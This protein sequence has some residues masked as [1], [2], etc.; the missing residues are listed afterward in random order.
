MT[1]SL[2]FAAGLAVTFVGWYL[3]GLISQPVAR[4]VVRATLIAVLCSPGVVI[5]HG[6]AVVPALFALAV[7]PTIYTLG[8]M[9]IVWV[10]A[11]AAILGVPALRRQSSTWPPVS[12]ELFVSGYPGKLLLLGVL[13]AV[14]MRALIF[15]SY[16]QDAAIMLLK[17]ALFFAGAAVNLVLSYRVARDLQAPP[18][19]IALPFALPSL[20]VASST[21]P[22]VWYAA[23]AIGGLAGSGRHTAANRIVVALFLFL[24]AGSLFR[25]YLAANAEAHV[26]I[27]GG[28][29]GNAAA[30]ILYA[31]MGIFS[32]W[33][34]RRLTVSTRAGEQ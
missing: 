30:A 34:L 1:L 10:A 7:Q 4:G 27:Q 21:V 3:A 15:A 13:A 8:L 16:Q 9:A 33:L 5:G 19:L 18:L 11:L 24:V 26:T 23:G 20:M 6:L 32:W 12:G 14:I 22:L 28:I 29:A 25:T 31:A 17:Y 2:I